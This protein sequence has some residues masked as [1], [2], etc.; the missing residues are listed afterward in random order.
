MVVPPDTLIWYLAVFR[1]MFLGMETAAASG[2][3]EAM[4][5]YQWAAD[6]LHNVPG[7]LLRHEDP[8]GWNSQENTARRLLD[9]PVLV[10]RLG[11]PSRLVRLAEGLVTREGTCEDLGLAADLRD[12]HFAPEAALAEHLRVLYGLCLET[13]Q[14]QPWAT[15]DEQ[16]WLDCEYHGRNNGLIGSVAK[17]L[18]PGL[19]RWHE[20]DP[21]RRPRSSKRTSE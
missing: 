2:D 12:L 16:G 18:P 15:L 17:G 5:L 9:F 19:V 14:R 1:R 20:F 11:V 3:R 10:A 4:W 6:A 7:M 8:P 21:S 13:R